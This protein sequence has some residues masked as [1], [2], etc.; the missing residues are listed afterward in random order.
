MAAN[1]EEKLRILIGEALEIAN[2]TPIIFAPVEG[3][4]NLR[5]SIG[6]KPAEMLFTKKDF[7][8]LVRIVRNGIKEEMAYS[9]ES[10]FVL[11]E[12]ATGGIHYVQDY[13]EAGSLSP[14]K[15]RLCSLTYYMCPEINPS[16]ITVIPA[17]MTVPISYLLE[18]YIA[19]ALKTGANQIGFELPLEEAEPPIVTNG[20]FKNPHP[21]SREQFCEMSRFLLQW[22][23][24]TEASQ[25]ASD[26]VVR[27]VSNGSVRLIKSCYRIQRDDLNASQDI[28]LVFHLDSELNPSKI[29]A[30]IQPGLLTFN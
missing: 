26:R 24:E 2:K 28:E 17:L 19:K 9:D 30:F 13:Y 21:F 18:L 23:S 29:T 10:E 4:N 20:C 7:N 27:D 16:Q 15:S 25:G 5:V 3:A 1:L 22:I 12:V 6:G 8:N 11:R 14:E